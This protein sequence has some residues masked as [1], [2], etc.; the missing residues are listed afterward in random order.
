MRP[1]H[2]SEDDSSGLKNACLQ[3]R[4]QHAEAQTSK[5]NGHVS[6]L[7]RKPWTGT[8][9]QEFLTCGHLTEQCS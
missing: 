6:R 5:T 9:V 2:V 8:H 1:V 7:G 4:V 3:K